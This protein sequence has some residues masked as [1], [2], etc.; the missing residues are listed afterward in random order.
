MI[1]SY[2]DYLDAALATAQGADRRVQIDSYQGR[3]G[4]TLAA[5]KKKAAPTPSEC[6]AIYSGVVL[7]AVYVEGLWI[8]VAKIAAKADRETLEEA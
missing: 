3:K 1:T 2:N 8:D 7:M 4:A 5:A 6:V